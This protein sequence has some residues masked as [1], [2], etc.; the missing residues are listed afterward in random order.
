ME[1]PFK[2]FCYLSFNDLIIDDD[3]T[4]SMIVV[5]AE[6]AQKNLGQMNNLIRSNNL[7]EF[8]IL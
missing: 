3:Q 8:D 5:F 4:A 7:V 2:Q 6:F 1:S